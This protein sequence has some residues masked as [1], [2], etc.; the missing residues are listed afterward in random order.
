MVRSPAI[1]RNLLLAGLAGIALIIG[2]VL[3]LREQPPDSP[4][5]L[6][7]TV[8]ENG[9]T[10]KNVPG[11]AVQILKPQRRDLVRTLTLSAN[12]SPWHQA[13]LYAKVPGYLKWMGFDKG[14]QVQKGQVLAEIDAPEVEQQ[15]RKAEAD[16]KIKQVT[17]QRL[18]NVWKEDPDVIAKQDVDVAKAEAEGARHN[19]DDRRT[20]LGYTKVYAPFSGVITAR[21]AD[22]GA[23][24]QAAT[25]SAAQAAPLYTVMDLNTVRVYV[26]VPQ[27]AALLALPGVP[28]IVTARELPGQQLRGTI[29]RTSKALDPTT[30]TLLV[31]VDLPN[32]EHRL[33]PGMFISV[34]LVLKEHKQALALPPAA[35]IPEGTGKAVF[36]VERDRARKMPVKTGL[37]DGVWVEIT[38][39]LMEDLDVVVVGKTGLSDGQPVQATPY[40]LP[41]GKP[42]SQKY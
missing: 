40:K 23:L 18:Y 14:D 39:G 34:T 8:Q 6:N 1:F 13:T 5:A 19:R 38:A 26:A 33:R 27:E 7:Q 25:G 11:T 21:F 3:V 28:A 32:P 42:A 2:L 10:P 29:T 16:Y 41:V 35:L 15:Y 22:P 24:I 30:R 37:D 9:Q 17:F 31:E 20:M 12:V 36:V 4:A